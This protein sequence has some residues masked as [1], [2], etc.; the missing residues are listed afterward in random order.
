M[1]R[2]TLNSDDDSLTDIAEFGNPL[3]N[4]YT[5]PRILGVVNG[6]ICLL[7]GTTNM[8]MFW[9]PAIRKFLIL[10]NPDP[11]PGLTGLSPPHFG[12]GFDP[13]ANDY[14]VVRI[15][16]GSTG[17]CVRI[18]KHSARSW[19]RIELNWEASNLP[20][21]F[22]RQAYL[23]GVVHW[24]G[25]DSTIV[26][27]DIRTEKFRVLQLPGDLK[28][29]SMENLGIAAWCG[30]LALF[31]LENTIKICLWVMEVY[32]KVESWTRQCV[33]SS[34]SDLFPIRVKSIGSHGKILVEG[35]GSLYWFDP[36]TR[37]TANLNI[38]GLGDLS[39]FHMKSY[40]ESLVL[41]ERISGSSNLHPTLST[42]TSSS[43]RK[44]SLYSRWS[45]EEEKLLVSAWLNVPKETGDF[46]WRRI[47]A[48]FGTQRSL[49]QLKQHWY[50][51]NRTVST[52]HSCYK[53]LCQL[54]KG[55]LDENDTIL[56]AYQVYK[57][58]ELAHFK[59]EHVWRI[60][61]DEPRWNGSERSSKRAKATE[62]G[63]Y[64]SSSSKRKGKE[65]FA[66][67]ED[68]GVEGIESDEALKSHTRAIAMSSKIKMQ[69]LAIKQREMD[70]QII[71]KGTS[72][73]TEEQL[74]IHQQLLSGA[75]K[76]MEADP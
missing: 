1:I 7:N 30:N 50:V 5:C 28:G 49:S 22:P 42:L 25:Y 66:E 76:R 43:M 11:I 24:I 67:M 64:A 3:P 51:I 29:K 52:F 68:S 12:F 59:H 15:D 35:F 14:K 18:Y 32:D 27:F 8:L 39:M 70:I 71:Y 4:P 6:L 75:I 10:P 56:K 33:I 61:K 40:T 54:H 45:H 13:L 36:S 72:G 26:G 58:E 55:S 37:E 63:E 41:L 17:P 44:R 34:P 16:Y 57:D 53:K 60:L 38:Q 47:E 48:Y 21:L 62:S 74:R 46:F 73:M 65:K 2:Y 20:S 69:E 9:N 31:E 23:N 19:S